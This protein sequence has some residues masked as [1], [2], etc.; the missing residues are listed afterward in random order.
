MPEAIEDPKGDRQPACGL[1]VGAISARPALSRRTPIGFC[2]R[3]FSSRKSPRS[4]STRN[5]IS[6]GSPNAP[7]AAERGCGRVGAVTARERTRRRNGGSR[8]ECQTRRCAAEA[9]KEEKK[10]GGPGRAVSAAQ[11]GTP[12]DSSS[13][14]ASSRRIFARSAAVCCDCSRL[15]IIGA[16]DPGRQGDCLWT[17]APAPV[18]R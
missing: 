5:S 7:K 4:R 14:R 18:S 8:R 17:S 16:K 11:T 3:L 1:P 13:V 12:F 2:L 10:G 6:R 9:A 15:E